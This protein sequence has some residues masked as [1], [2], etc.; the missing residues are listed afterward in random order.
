MSFDAS[1]IIGSI[2]S[3][4]SSV[5]DMMEG[6]AGI[7][8]PAVMLTKSFELMKEQQKLTIMSESFNKTMKASHDAQKEAIKSMN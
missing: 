8:D 7:D 6:L 1:S 2:G 4:Q 3:K 5:N